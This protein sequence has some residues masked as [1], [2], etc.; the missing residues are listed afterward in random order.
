M[1]T[2]RRRELA[3]RSALGAAWTRLAAQQLTEALVLAL[4]GGLI[5]VGVIIIDELLRASKRGSLP[6]LAVGMGIYLPMSLTLLIPVG[7]ALTACG[8]DDDSLSGLDAVSISGPTGKAPKL[9]WKGRMDADKKAT[10]VLE[11]GEGAALAKGDQVTCGR[12]LVP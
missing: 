8:G 9:D 7:F 3:L 4:T 10:K 6:P 1:T 12:L 2:S 5:G 11:K